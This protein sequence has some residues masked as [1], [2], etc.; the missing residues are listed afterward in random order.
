MVAAVFLFEG[1]VEILKLA[2]LAPA[3]IAILAGTDALAGVLLVRA[4][5]APPA[6]AALLSV[7]VPVELAPPETFGGFKTSDESVAGAKEVTVMRNK[8]D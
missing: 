1:V 7:P 8:L 6:G 3:A 4:I 2:K 5:T